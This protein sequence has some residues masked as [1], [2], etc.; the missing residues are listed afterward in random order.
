MSKTI[1]IIGASSGIGEAAVAAPKATGD[2]TF[3]NHSTRSQ[4]GV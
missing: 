3:F 1:L 2:A 4:F